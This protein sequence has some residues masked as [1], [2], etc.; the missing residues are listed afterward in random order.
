MSITH[1]V[2]LLYHFLYDCFWCVPLYFL[3]F[4]IFVIIFLG[5]FYFSIWYTIYFLCLC[6]RCPWVCW[7]FCWIT[8][9]KL[10]FC[11]GML[12]WVFGIM[13]VCICLFVFVWCAI[14]CMCICTYIHI[15]KNNC[16]MSHYVFNLQYN[17]RSNCNV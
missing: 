12:W 11:V 16:L 2:V 6:L 10:P 4:Y 1:L 15:V 8:I 17:K 5:C 7:T 9:V 13:Y 14:T 3:F